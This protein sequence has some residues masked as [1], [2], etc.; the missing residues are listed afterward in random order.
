M[1]H[2]KLAKNSLTWSILEHNA[3]NISN[4]LL[5]ARSLFP[6]ISKTN[7]QMSKHP[8]TLSKTSSLPLQDIYKIFFVNI[9]TFITSFIE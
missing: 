1:D 4:I 2:V 8:E 3:S 5:F 9:N 7:L 6:Q